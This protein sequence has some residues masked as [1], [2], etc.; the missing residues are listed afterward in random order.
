[1]P[2]H[3]QPWLA[4][5]GV[6]WQGGLQR[7]LVRVFDD[8]I[9]V[10][11]GR[12]AVDTVTIPMGDVYDVELSE[13]GAL[14]IVVMPDDIVVTEGTERDRALAAELIR[15]N[16]PA[17]RKKPKPKPKPKPEPAPEPP[18]A[19]PPASSAVAT[20]DPPRQRRAARALALLTVGIVFA[21]AAIVLLIGGF[22][23][24]VVRVF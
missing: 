21:A 6:R 2:P 16:A 24:V 17:P 18:P 3:D 22:A 10:R 5:S 7:R 20:Q 13:A 9:E 14:R 1:M 11:A 23:W 8:R 15:K 4:F 12:F 19:P